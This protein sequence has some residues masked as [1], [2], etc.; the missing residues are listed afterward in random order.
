MRQSNSWRHSARRQRVLA[1]ASLIGVAG[2][3]LGL[4]GPADAAKKTTKKVGKTTKAA[5][6]ASKAKAAP[7]AAIA[8][9]YPDAQVI[10]LASGKDV[11]L[12]SLSAEGKPT[13]IFIWAPS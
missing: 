12:A 7:A 5:K 13:L 9:V 10:D 8:S 11:S 1:V 2:L 3:V 4:A 6:S